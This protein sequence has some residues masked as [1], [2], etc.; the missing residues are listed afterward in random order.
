MSKIFSNPAGDQLLTYFREIF[1]NKR[2]YQRRDRFIL[3]VCGGQL[4]V[5][6]S[7]LRKQFMEWAEVNLPQ[8]ICLLAEDA[9]KDSFAGEGR[10]FVNLASFESIIAEVADAVLIFPESAGSL[11]E[12]GFFAS[13]EIRNKT[14]VVNPYRFQAEDSFLNRG[15]FDTINR[16]SFLKLLIINDD[17][18][19]DFVQVQQRL[20]TGV[21]WPEHRE[22]LAHKTFGKFTFKE[23]LFVVFETLRLLR[24]ADLKTLRYVVVKCFGGNPKK[25]ELTHLLRILLAAKLIKREEHYFRAMPNLSL[26]DIERLEVETVFARVNFYYQK[27]FP[28]LYRALNETTR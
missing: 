23:K 15:P 11:A 13:S 18:I 2:I 12:A 6:P 21:R 20:L 8:F 25:Q 10:T 4:G 17:N 19:A 14:L 26:V 28:E 3:F 22:R 7:S 24:L 27:H 9:L 5:Q 16:D 1:T